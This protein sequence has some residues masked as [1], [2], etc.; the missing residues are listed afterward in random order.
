M[1]IAVSADHAGFPLK[2]VVIDTIEAMG[3]EAIDL[4]MILPESADYPDFAEK[5]A[6]Q[7]SRGSR[8]GCR[9]LRLRRGCCS[10]RQNKRMGVY[11]CLCH[12]TYSCSSGGA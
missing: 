11:A 4:G 7:L 8:S 9:N 2:K 1:K 10:L 5:L 3:H 6:W 12:D